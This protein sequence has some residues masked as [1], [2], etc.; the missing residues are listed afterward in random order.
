MNKRNIAPLIALLACFMVGICADTVLS[1][2]SISLREM[3]VG[4]VVFV[5]VSYI[6]LDLVIAPE[7][8]LWY[9]IEKNFPFTWVTPAFVRAMGVFC[10]LMSLVFGWVFIG[11]LLGLIK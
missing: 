3:I 6:G 11:R 2:W 8:S 4:L 7:T 1:T 9:R 5:S 10:I